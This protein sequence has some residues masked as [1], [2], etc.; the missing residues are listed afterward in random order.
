M[1]TAVR[2]EA[3]RCYTAV[4]HC[5]IGSA[6]SRFTPFIEQQRSV[7]KGEYHLLQ[8]LVLLYVQDK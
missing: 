3:H 5:G 8:I 6:Q 2:P 1:Y 7:G 4:Y